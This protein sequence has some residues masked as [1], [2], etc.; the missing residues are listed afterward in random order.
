MKQECFGFLILFIF[1]FWGGGQIRYEAFVY[2]YIYDPLTRLRLNEV[3]CRY[4]Y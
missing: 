2:L 3:L 1:F 4:F